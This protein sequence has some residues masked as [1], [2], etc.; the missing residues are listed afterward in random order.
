VAKAPGTELVAGPSDV[1]VG[2]L[3]AKHVVLTVREKNGCDPGF[4]FSWEDQDVGALWPHTVVGVTIDVW[5]VDV[6][7]TRLF[8]EAET[9]RQADR[10]LQREIRQIVGSIRFYQAAD[11]LLDLDTGAMTPLPESIVGAEGQRSQYAHS[12]DGSTLA[13]VAPGED[14]TDQIFVADLDGSGAEQVTYDPAGAAWPAWSPDGT[15]IAY[16]GSGG[17]LAHLFVL[18]VAAG[19]V[20]QITDETE[21]L[22]GS[23][24]QFTPDGS[25]LIYT[26]GS[27]IVPE[28]RTIP[29]TGGE[30]TIRFGAGRGGMHDAGNG[31]MSPDGALVTMMGSEIGGP[32]AIRFVANTDGT[33]LRNI[34]GGASDPSGTWSPDGSR[35]V[36]SRFSGGIIV[37]DIATGDATF[38]AEGSSAIWLDDHTLLIDV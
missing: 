29:V 2:G 35:I 31:S 38:V 24:L 9:T 28:L 34:P 37:V 14:G 21:L 23:G 25:S 11:Y 33:E 8:I 26:G 4:F 22:P 36:C 15:S 32:G 1:T 12:P 27:G 30:S 3:P 5:I 18:D 20:T 19:E 6:D 10:D 17:E 16:E 7:G 13:Y